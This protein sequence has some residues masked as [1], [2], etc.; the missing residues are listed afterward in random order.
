MSMFS[1]TNVDNSFSFFLSSFPPS[2]CGSF[3]FLFRSSRKCVLSPS[4]DEREEE[5]GGEGDGG[6]RQRGGAG[7]CGGLRRRHPPKSST[8]GNHHMYEYILVS[9][10]E[11]RALTSVYSVYSD[12]LRHEK[13]HRVM[14]RPDTVT[15]SHRIHN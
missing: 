8:G 5:R 6:S 2:G 15:S 10:N 7:A 3:H 4:G 9:C 13:F 14:L 12:S 11:L 1:R